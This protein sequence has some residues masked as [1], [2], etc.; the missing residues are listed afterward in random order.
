MK[1]HIVIGA[2]FGDE[3][4]GLATNFLAGNLDDN[5]VV[6]FNGGGQA[7]HTVELDDGRRHIFHHISSGSFQGS[8]TFLTEHFIVNPKV[9]IKAAKA[10]SR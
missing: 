7:A 3:G 10:M 9:L 2:N 1:A 5:I 4:K 8:P 6:R